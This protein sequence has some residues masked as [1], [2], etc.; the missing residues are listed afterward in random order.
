MFSFFNF[1]NITLSKTPIIAAKLNPDILTVSVICIPI[2]FSKKF[3]ERP[4]INIATI[5]MI[6][7]I[8][9]STFY[10]LIVL[11]PTIA[12]IENNIKLIPPITGCGIVLIA[13]PNFATK[14]NNIAKIAVNLNI[15]GL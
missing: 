11:T 9:N 15:A 2:A 4:I 7:Q 3:P 10:L 6:L 5:T 13:A 14:L 12:I 8:L 1:V